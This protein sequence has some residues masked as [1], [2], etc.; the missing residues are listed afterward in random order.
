MIYPMAVLPA[1]LYVISGIGSRLQKGAQM[2]KYMNMSVDPCE[3]FYEFTCGNWNRY[4]SAAK[5]DATSTGLLENLQ[6]SLSEKLMEILVTPEQVDTM[7]DR[8]VKD[9]YRSCLN[10]AA[11]KN[12]YA[13]KLRELIAEFGEMPALAG[14]AWQEQQ[15]DWLETVAKI[16]YKYGIGILTP[17]EVS[18]DLVDTR[19]NRL[20]MRTADLSLGNQ[21]VYLDKSSSQLLQGITIVVYSR[22]IDFLGMEVELAKRTAKE[23][24]D[25][26]ISLAR[27]IED[28]N[29]ATDYRDVIALDTIDSLQQKY[30]GYL[31]LKK[32]L[33]LSFGSLPNLKVYSNP[34]YLKHL[35]ELMHVTPRRVVA[36]YIFY[37][38]IRK[39]LVEVP[40]TQQKLQE[41]C[42]KGMKPRFFKIFDNMIYRRFMSREIEQGIHS[43]WEE[44]K[45][46]FKQNLASQKYHWIDGQIRRYAI[47]KVNAMK[48]DIVS[49]KDY[50]FQSSFGALT[51]NN[52]DYIENLKSLYAVA[53]KNHRDS[54]TKPPKPTELGE[55][56]STSPANILNENMVKVPVSMLQP[57]QVWSTQ[58]PNAF[59]YAVLG[60]LLSHEL[61]HGFDDAGR[62]YDL[63]GKPLQWWDLLSSIYFQERSECF[64][65]QYH[66]YVFHNRH[67]PYMSQDENIADNGGV[68]LAYNAYLNWYRDALQ[69]YPHQIS[70][71]M[72][73]L[74]FSDK[75][76]FFISYGQLWCGDINPLIRQYQESTDAHVPDKFRVIGPLSNFEEFSKEFQCPPGSGMNP[77]KKCEIY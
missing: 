66:G 42:L 68:R 49:Y 21:H 56:L 11:L 59:N 69:K 70:E 35:I 30:A 64:N 25:F 71:T 45:H 52:H 51:V 40:K 9:F 27:G 41:N 67:L 7:V 36:N 13:L 38:L 6:K 61:I 8:K 18:I 50:D 4:H 65:E 43:M 31:D 47:E 73:G 17:A 63:H 22:L 16:S 12:N 76:L 29:T 28:V 60:A 20:Y 23:I 57:Y 37:N 39:F 48:M 34:K 1:S 14:P 74:N 26:E 72:P 33:Y 5:G 55:E 77:I 53:S 46:T 2:L 15:F 54:I 62:G 3:D 10:L 32:L 24:I 44:I 58:F 19:V 75:K